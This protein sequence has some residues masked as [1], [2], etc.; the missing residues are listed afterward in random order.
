MEKKRSGRYPWGTREELRK[1][2]LRLRDAGYSVSE[3]AKDMG[4]KESTVRELSV[5]LSVLER[6]SK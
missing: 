3:I 2:M 6:D 4:I 1:R 5:D